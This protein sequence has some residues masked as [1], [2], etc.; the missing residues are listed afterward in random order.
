MAIGPRVRALFGR[1][2]VPVTDRYR[3]CFID[4]D[5]LARR[6]RA[7]APASHILEVGCGEGALL[8]RLAAL[9]PEARLTGIDITPRVGRLYR[10]DP[11][12]ATFRRETVQDFAR[13]HAGRFDLVVLSDVLH[14]VPWDMHRDLL[15]A[16]AR[17]LAPGGRL[18]LKDWERRRNPA[19]LFAYL[20][21]RYL[22]GDRIRFAM[23]DY[24]RALVRDLFGPDCIEHE[25][26]VPPWRNNLVFLTR[27]LPSAG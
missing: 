9:Y 15:A 18:V 6:V 1:W 23:A 26:R 13:D 12:R 22:T 3:A 14:H 16:A 17:A 4:L 5:S 8:E 21:D 10:G 19:H 7:W 25:L 11:A 20:S 24:F 2:E 27:L